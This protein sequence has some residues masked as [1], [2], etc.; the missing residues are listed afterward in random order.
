MDRPNAIVSTRFTRTRQYECEPG[1]YCIDGIRYRCPAGYYGYAPRLTSAWCSGKCDSGYYC[2]LAST[3]RTQVRFDNSCL[4]SKTDI[5]AA[6]WGYQRVLSIR[7]S[8]TN[9]CT[10]RPLHG[11]GGSHYG[12]SRLQLHDPRS[13][14]S[15]RKGPL[16]Y[17]REKIQV[18]CRAVRCL[19]WRDFAIRSY[20]NMSIL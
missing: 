20:I 14:V 9:P 8:S 11:E 6:M 10:P 19:R 5:L 17:Q 13:P 18:S 4:R 2:P 16:L 12:F 15:V 7:K 3:S 1:Y